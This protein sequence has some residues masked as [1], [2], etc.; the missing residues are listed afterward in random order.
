MVQVDHGSNDACLVGTA[1]SGCR[2]MA[3]ACRIS[4]TEL[5]GAALQQGKQLFPV[6]VKVSSYASCARL[7]DSAK[8]NKIRLHA[9]K[10]FDQPT[11]GK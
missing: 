4:S 11:N 7:A 1:T 5:F 3:T 2:T 6:P 8:R 10:L 9:G